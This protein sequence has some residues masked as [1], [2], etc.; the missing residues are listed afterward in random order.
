MLKVIASST[1]WLDADGVGTGRYCSGPPGVDVA[2]V[3]ATLAE[4]FSEVHE[5]PGRDLM[6][7]VDGAPADDTRA[8]YLMPREN[9][10]EG[11]G[12]LQCSRGV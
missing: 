1:R 8:V 9:M 6:P 7:V 2:A 10:P 3:P 4:S 12:A 5:L 11:D